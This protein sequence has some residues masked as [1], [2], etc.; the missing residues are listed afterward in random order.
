MIYTSTSCLKN[1]SDIIKVLAEYEKHEIEN[2]ELGSVHKFFETKQLK[3]F[4]F[5][6]IV[7]GYFPP[8][9]I[10]FNFNLASQNPIIRKKSI[11]LVKK[12]VNVCCDIES[13]IFTFHAGFTVDPNK[14]GRRFPREGIVNRELARNTF[15]D[16][17]E[18]ILDYSHM[19]G[20]KLAMELNVVQKFNLDNYE[21]RLLLFADFDETKIFLNKFHKRGIGIL[22]D[23]GHTAVTSHWLKFDK[24]QFVK[25]I[26]KYVSVIHASNNNG[27]QDQ[28]K[29]LTKNCWQTL[30][31]RNFKNKP[32]TLE[33]MNLT[34]EQIKQNIVIAED[35]IK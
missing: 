4:N 29:S 24:D 23:L 15:F 28:H 18:I 1:P 12:A 32:I 27:I 11:D 14:L 31:L 20:I 25:K 3:R 2:V 34:V 22:L 6:F 19:R 17:S 16:S 5:N 21:N 10:P 33:T 8:P 35:A 9:R 30:V 13:P 7:H 26:K